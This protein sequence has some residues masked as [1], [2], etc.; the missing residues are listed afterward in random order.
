[1]RTLLSIWCLLLVVGCAHTPSHPQA[2]PALPGV[3]SHNVTLGQNI[4]LSGKFTMRGK[5][6]PLVV[7]DGVV[8]YLLPSAVTTG[9]GLDEFEGRDVT[10][11]GTLHFEEYYEFVGWSDYMVRPF[12]HFYF[13]AETV[14]VSLKL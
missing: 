1:M 7:C 11:T 3:R 13:D 14:K 6:G 12:D 9:R 5:L 8:F 2:E 4:C 10:V